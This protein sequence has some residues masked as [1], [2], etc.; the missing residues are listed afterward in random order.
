MKK[1]LACLLVAL[2]TLSCVQDKVQT[3]PPPVTSVSVEVKSPSAPLLVFV[4][5]MEYVLPSTDWESVTSNKPEVKSMASNKKEQNLV[6][7]VKEKY[8]G[9][10]DEYV[11]S[12][13][14]SLKD[15]G[16]FVVGATQSD[17]NGLKWVF[18]DSTKNDVR[19]L[20]WI[21]VRNGFGYSL[22]CGGKGD[23][24]L[25]LQV[26]QQIANTLKLN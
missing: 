22:S 8:A 23:P 4:E 6:V 11:L 9:E 24:E 20:Q 1:I 2:C 19:L 15:Q 21:T 12:N 17:L 5:D 13:I 10:Y 7:M 18:V 25:Q 26:C 14:R 16:A 3:N